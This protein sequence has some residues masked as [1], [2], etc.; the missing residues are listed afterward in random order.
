[1]KSSINRVRGTRIGKYK[2]SIDQINCEEVS[3]L[4]MK[5][6][7]RILVK[8]IDIC[9]L[10]NKGTSIEDKLILLQTYGFD[11]KF[12][13]SPQIL[14]KEKWFYWHILRQIR[15]ICFEGNIV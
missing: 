8:L 14:K 10:L 13:I 5:V 3:K 15:K 9:K 12:K 7:T 6:P 1:M 4:E 11:S 2:N